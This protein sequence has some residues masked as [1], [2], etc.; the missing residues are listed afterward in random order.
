MTLLSELLA[1]T[2]TPEEYKAQQR[3]WVIGQLMLTHPEMTRE[4]AEAIY[5]KAV[6]E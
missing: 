3:S 2:M 6:G 4:K 1:R 5:D